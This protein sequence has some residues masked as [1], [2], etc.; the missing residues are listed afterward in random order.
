[1]NIHVSGFCSLTGRSFRYSGEL[2]IGLNNRESSISVTF[3][4]FFS[5][6]ILIS[7]ISE[8]C[9]NVFKFMFLPWSFML[10]Y[11]IFF[12]SKVLLLH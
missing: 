2:F 3:F 12:I 10:P 6:Y 5:I 9:G 7:Y 1:M 4:F 8:F 11:H